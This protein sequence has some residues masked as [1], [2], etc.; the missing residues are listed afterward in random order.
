MWE[1]IE[2][3]VESE[4]HHGRWR[5][6]GRRLLLE[7]RGGRSYEWCGLLRP[8]VVAAQSLKRLVSHPPLAA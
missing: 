6:E 7:W 4:R 2:V 1:R 5:M 8:E 3:W